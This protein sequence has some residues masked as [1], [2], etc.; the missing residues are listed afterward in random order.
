MKDSLPILR[1]RRERRLAGLRKSEGRRRSALLS[2]GMALSLILATLILVTALAYADLTRDLPSIELLPRLLNPPDGLLLQPTRIYDRSGQHLLVTFAPDDSPRAYILLNQESPNH[3]PQALADGVVAMADPGFWDHSGYAI[4]GWEDPELHP[5]IAQ[6]LVSDLLLYNE[7]PSLRRAIRERILASQAVA[8]Y[9][10]AQVL[11]WYL[12]S[13]NFG[14]YAFGAEA[15]ARLYF[16]RPASELNIAEAAILA[17]VSESPSLNPLDAP[18]PALQRGRELIHVLDSLELIS[19]DEADRALTLPIA[20]QPAPPAAP[21][22]APAFVN[23]VLSQ[24]DSLFSR[25]RVERGGLTIFTTLD[26]DLQ[27]QASCITA[28][29]SARLAGAPDPKTGC[30]S[31][32]LL[33]SLPPDASVADPTSSAL[34]LDPAT[35]QVLAVVG[36]TLQGQETASLKPHDPGSLVTPFIYLTGFTRGLSPASLVWDIP[37][38]IDIQN[39]DGAYHGPIRARIALANDYR[40]PAEMMIQQMGAENVSKIAASFGLSLDQPHTL[41]ELAGAYGA[42]ATNGVY[43]GQA[44]GTD[45]TTGS[46]VFSPV[47]ILRVETAD[48]AVLLDWSTPQARPIVASSLAYL[49]T[50]SLSDETARWPSLGSPNALEIGRPAAAKLGQTPEGDEAWAIGYTP[51]R[52]VAVWTT[53]RTEGGAIAPRLP[54]VLWNALIQLASGD[55]PRD[56]WP[57]PPGISVLNV[58]DPSGLL[59]SADCPNVVSEVFA[60]GSEPAQADTLYRAYYINRETGYLATVFTPAQL[61]E[62]RVYMIMPAEAKEWALSTGIEAPP[63]SYDAIQPPPRNPAVN[64]T[65]PELFAQVSGE[66]RIMGTAAGDDFVSYRLQVGKGLNPQEWIQISEDITTPV[67]NGLLAEWDTSELSGLY[68]VQLIV[69]RE[70]QRLET[71]V[72]QVTIENP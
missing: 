48:R 72:I 68:A 38:R 31:A 55:L 15:A 17:A 39:F 47:T 60:N 49:I 22:P 10:R 62:K 69:V 46:D 2:V 40:V 63:D 32:R 66:V 61:V 24:F 37:G 42:F 33:P 21:Q 27:A 11:E 59:P 8:E 41:L 34:I 23:L 50:S 64:I 20:I 65:L 35:G 19:A 53:A 4:N 70:D 56:G 9:G 1:T 28:V 52:V 12:N 16:G 13:A 43:F 54:A 36:E 7:P 25:E 57:V 6:R 67:E 5:T 44:L 30:E 14:H 26:F 18:Q 45:Q 71:A 51:F 58:C 29:Y 3:L